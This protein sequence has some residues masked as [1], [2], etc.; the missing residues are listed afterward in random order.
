MWRS[1]GLGLTPLQFPADFGMVHLEL[2]TVFRERANV[3]SD[4]KSR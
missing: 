3:S 1:S 4:E 2:K